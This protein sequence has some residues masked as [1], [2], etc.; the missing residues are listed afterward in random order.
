MDLG[1]N[2]ETW[3]LRDDVDSKFRKQVFAISNDGVHVG[4]FFVGPRDILLN[5]KNEV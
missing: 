2:S 1:H 3:W 5:A 4:I